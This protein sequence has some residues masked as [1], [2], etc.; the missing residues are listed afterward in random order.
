M[1]GSVLKALK[2]IVESNLPS[3]ETPVVPGF[4][5]AQRNIAHLRTQAESWFA[6]LF[7]VYGSVGQEGK[8][9]VGDVISAW[10]KIAGE[11]EIV[12][13]YK[14]VITLFKQNLTN[15][16]KSHPKGSDA[17]NMTLMAQ[18][19]LVLLLP[20]LPQA[21]CQEL[22]TLCT[23]S[24]VVGNGDA[25]IQKRGYRI[26]S[27][28]VQT[29]KLSSELNIEEILT[30]LTASADSVGAPAKR[31]RITL[32]SLL[33]PRLPSNSLHIIPTLIPEAVLATKE[34]AER[35][36]NAAFDLIVAMGKKMKDGGVVMRSRLDGMDDDATDE[37][38][39]Y[40]LS[41]KDVELIYLSSAS[42]N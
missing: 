16:P 42:N 19:L 18:D 17:P 4:G 24:Q 9:M 13:M 23:S 6:V 36:R 26:L 25:A 15:P 20:E 5:D 32:V 30:G 41:L 2:V 40:A 21:Q 28:L 29:S 1:R 35:T 12:T 14:K 11:N 31:D 27:K 3:E 34:P 38:E 10:V 22:W 33:L 7:N 39:V 8:S 37:G